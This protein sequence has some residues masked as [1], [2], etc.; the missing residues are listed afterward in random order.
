MDLNGKTI[1]IV[2]SGLSGAT[3]CALLKDF[4]KIKVFETRS[5]IA[6]NCF[7]GPLA[8]IFIHHYGPHIFHTD[9]EEVFLFLS[10]YTEWKEFYLRPKG[11]T[12][13]GLISLPYSKKTISEIG[14][15]LSEE[16]I[17]DLIFKDYSEKQ[18]GVDFNKIPKSITNRIPKT[19]DCENPTWFEGQKYQCIPKYGYTKMIEKM[20]DGA[21]IYL[22]CSS[23]EWKKHDADMTIYTGKIDDFYEQKFGKL[24]YRSLD[25]KHFVSNEKQD[26]FIINENTKN[27]LYTRRY[28]QR[29][30]DDESKSYTVITEEYP[31]E[32]KDGDIPYYPIPFGDGPEIYKK[33]EELAKNEKNIIFLGRLAT[34]KYLDMWMAVKQ[35]MLKL[36]NFG[37]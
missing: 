37:L 23:D 10:K 12:K 33:Y 13:I 18:W 6:G 7:D 28:D 8:N 11:N 14:R 20:L 21:E 35:A 25:F 17:V 36:K 3:A 26:H 2:G 22:N 32:Y 1:K 27:F 24:P 16:E 31:K 9:D 4:C 5:H 34:Y 19:K 29:F 30:F 15:Q